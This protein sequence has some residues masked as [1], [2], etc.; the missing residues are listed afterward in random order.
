[1]WTAELGMLTVQSIMEALTSRK[2]FGIIQVWGFALL[3]SHSSA[4]LGNVDEERK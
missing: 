2:Y 1:M 4:C 3:L